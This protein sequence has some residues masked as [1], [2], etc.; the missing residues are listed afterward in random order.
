MR[1]GTAH[2]LH[3]EHTEEVEAVVQAGVEVA[4]SRSLKTKDMVMPDVEQVEPLMR[5]SKIWRVPPVPPGYQISWNW[6]ARTLSPFQ[7][8]NVGEQAVF[9][10]AW[11]HEPSQNDIEEA[12]LDW[13]LTR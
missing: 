1:Q 9:V 13:L 2:R 6:I 10:T 4:R 5:H 7:L 12:I 11:T 8:W 3:V